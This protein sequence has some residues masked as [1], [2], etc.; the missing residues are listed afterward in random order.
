MTDNKC[1]QR[2]AFIAGAGL[3]A[4]D[5]RSGVQGP[6]HMSPIGPSLLDTEALRGVAINVTSDGY[7]KLPNVLHLNPQ[8]HVFIIKAGFQNL[9]TMYE[10]S[11][12]EVARRSIQCLDLNHDAFAKSVI[13]EVRLSNNL[14]RAKQCF[15]EAWHSPFGEG[16]LPIREIVREGF[17]NNLIY[18]YRR[19]NRTTYHLYF[20]RD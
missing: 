4:L 6:K 9:L 10:Q 18:L 13:G 17:K 12:F 2:R 16:W 7:A 5:V 14:E 11:A 15:A 3:I 19:R 20:V 8:D 1:I